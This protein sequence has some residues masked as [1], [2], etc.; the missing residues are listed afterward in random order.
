MRIL[1]N[2]NTLAPV[3]G[4]EMAMLQVNQELSRRG[5]DINAL[6]RQGGVQ[7]QEWRDLAESLVQVPTFDFTKR[8]AWRDLRA[9]RPAVRAAIDAQ[10][11]ILHLNRVE[12]SVWGLLASRRA[13]VPIVTTVRNEPQFPGVGLVGRLT[14]HFIAVSQYMRRRWTE[15]GVPADRITVIGNGVRAEEYPVGGADELRRARADLGIAPTEFVV[16]YYGRVA[17]EKGVDVLL[18]AWRRMSVHRGR[19]MIVGVDEF[20]PDREHLRDLQA[21]Q[22]RG[23]DW[24]PLQ[25]NVVPYLHAADVIVL[26]AL[27][28][29]PFGR[30]VIEGMATGRP[31][32]ASRVGGIPETLT[33]EFA[34]MLVEPGDS[35]AL[36]ARISELQH[37][38]RDDPSLG[39][40]C[41]DHIRDNFTLTR[42]VDQIE[43]VF[44]NAARSR[45]APAPAGRVA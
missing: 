35:G 25:Q 32:V 27:W 29:E 1:V 17:P 45:R 43:A 42:V 5:H 6:Y 28:Q 21:A 19:L 9:L 8:T 38:R 11:D 7:E 18:E 34:S 4:V 12:Q 24:V 15:A 30:V 31:V 13:G 16:L 39:A 41:T 44:Q 36:A 33:G 10:P 37:W 14:T 2:P 26:P 23:C 22:P 3:G 20:G 40:R